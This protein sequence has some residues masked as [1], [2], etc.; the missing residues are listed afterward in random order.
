MLI[1]LGLLCLYTGLYVARTYWR[2][3]HFPGPLVARFTDLGRLWW[4][5]TSRSHHHHMGLHSRYG[6]YVRLGPNMISISDPD[7]IPLVYPIRPGVPKSDFYRSMMPYTR[8]GRSLPL[9][10]NTRDEDLHKR[11]KTPIAHLY[12]LSNILTFEAFVDQVLEILFRQFEERFVPDQAPFNLGNWLQYFAF[13]VMGTMSFSRRY[14]FLEKG[15]DDTGLLSAIW[16]FMKAAAPVTQ[17]PWVDLVW[18]K[19]PFI[20]LFRATP[21]Q[22]ILNVVLSRIND[23]RNELYSTTSTPEKV[24][25]RDFLSRFM[26]IQSNSDTIP[27]WAVTAWSFSNVIAGSDTTAVAMKTLWYNLLLHPATMHR[28]RKELVQAQQQ[29]KL[30]HPFPAWNEISGLPYLNACVNEALRIHPPFC[31]PFERIVPA[32]GMTIGD[33]FF[34]GGTVIGMNPWVINRHRPTFGED[35]DAWR[36]ERWLEDPART[37][38]ME[39]TLLSFGAG[40]RVCLG[41]NIALL[42]LKKLTSALVLHYELEI[43]NPEKFQSQNFFFFKQEGLYAAVKRRSAG[44]PELYPDDAVPH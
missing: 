40:R 26:H 1:L 34:P 25:E 30:S 43:V 42:E 39:N 4:V 24:N 44:S 16:A 33:H 32:E 13:D 6:Q 21:A 8:K 5:K 23:R 29:S 10:F 27:P 14:G 22:P 15:R 31:L 37:R 9:V 2:L 18:N 36:P 35:A 41:K 19:N 17:M 7:A 3:R 11:L 38:Q 20:A 28:L 12:S